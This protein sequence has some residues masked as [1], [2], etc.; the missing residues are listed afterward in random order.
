VA[1][2]ADFF[3]W[4]G[5]AYVHL[6]IN[7]WKPGNTRGVVRPSTWIFG[8]AEGFPNVNPG[9]QWPFDPRFP[10]NEFR[11]PYVEVSGSLIADRSHVDGSS[12]AAAAAAAVGWWR[13]GISNDA[14]ESPVRA[15]EVHPPD[16]IDL[17]APAT[18]EESLYGVALV[19]GSG[20]FDSREQQIEALLAPPED[21]PSP[22][23][24]AAVTELVGPESYLDT[25]FI[26]NGR[27]TGADLTLVSDSTVRVRAGVRSVLAGR[28]GKFRA[29][30]RVFWERLAVEDLTASGFVFIFPP[31]VAIRLR[32]P[33]RQALTVRLEVR[34]DA[35]PWAVVVTEDPFGSSGALTGP[36]HA[37]QVPANLPDRSFCFWLGR[38]ADG[39]SH[40]G[41]DGRYTFR[42]TVVRIAG[43][44]ATVSEVSTMITWPT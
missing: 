10:T 31:T 4:A 9:T 5:T 26:G 11:P 18:A 6:E 7:G 1:G 29:L 3:T 36:W 43:G 32:A 37:R 44:T 20:L 16:R 27:L 35:G 30:Y 12:P 34:L 25:L 24:Y 21:P 39:S 22:A 42:L 8:D 15:A 41:R 40:R 13:R 28:V 14:E 33:Q 19:A 2:S 17:L 23:H 38:V